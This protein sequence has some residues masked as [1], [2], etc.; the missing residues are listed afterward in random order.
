MSCMIRRRAGDH[1]ENL[2]ELCPNEWKLREQIEALE[3]WLMGNRESLSPRGEWV[4]DVGFCVR[5]NAAG[6]GPRITR[7]LMGMC[8]EVNMEI[9]LSEYP[10]E[11]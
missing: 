6:G 8:L 2:T 3:S 9:F 10:G 11:A 4:A 7:N 1:Y 5:A